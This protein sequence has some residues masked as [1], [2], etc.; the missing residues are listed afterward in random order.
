MMMKTRFF[1]S[2]PLLLMTMAV[3][4]QQNP[5]TANELMLESLQKWQAGKMVS[6][7]AIE[8]FGGIGKCFMAEPIPDNVWQ[9]MAGKTYV[10]NPHIGRKDLRHIKVLHRNIDGDIYIGEMV[11]NQ[12]IAADLVDIFRQLYEADYPIE[13]MVLPDVYDADDER[14]MQA[15]NT[16][17][18][19]YRV[20]PN[21]KTLSRHAMGMAVDIN[22]LYNPY[23]VPRKNASPNV[24]PKTA[25]KYVDRSRKFPY[26]LEKGDLC[27]QL[28]IQHGFNWGGNWKSSKD[29]QHF[30]KR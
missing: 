25:G 16:S 2:V 22:T 8:S 26:K 27:Y 7:E 18:F 14:Q 29:Y 20:V 21:T 4:A 19:C 13:R 23:V 30:D 12:K 11:C 10:D 28:F 6:A 24:M 5:K 17:C 15:N 3:A 1:F 9:R